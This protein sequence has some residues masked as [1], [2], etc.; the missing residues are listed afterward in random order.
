MGEEA[1]SRDDTR[2]I[3][4]HE[5]RACEVLVKFVARTVGMQQL[6]AEVAVGPQAARRRGL[7]Q[8]ASRDHETLVRLAHIEGADLASPIVDVAHDRYPRR[9]MDAMVED[10][11]SVSAWRE[12]GL[13]VRREDVACVRVGGHMLDRETPGHY[14]LHRIAVDSLQWARSRAKPPR[15]GTGSS[16]PDG[17][18]ATR[19]TREI[20]A[21]SRVSSRRRTKFP[22]V[23]ARC[24]PGRAAGTRRRERGRSRRRAPEHLPRARHLRPRGESAST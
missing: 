12:A 14:A 24:L 18:D 15:A 1:R 9:D 8:R 2:I 11:L 19:T 10:E 3:A 20:R 7:D 6:P 23:S 22:T 21:S 16:Q 13:V 17:P 4:G 5:S